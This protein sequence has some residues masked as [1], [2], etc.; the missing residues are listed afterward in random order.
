[1]FGL[2]KA[3]LPNSLFSRLSALSLLLPLSG[4]LRV[5]ALLSF[6]HGCEFA[7]LDVTDVNKGLVHMCWFHAET[8][9]LYT[10]IIKSSKN[11]PRGKPSKR[12]RGRCFNVSMFSCNNG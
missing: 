4:Q 12:M 9:Q 8:S 1:M 10:N 11:V 3:E 5:K 2:Y 6:D 7:E